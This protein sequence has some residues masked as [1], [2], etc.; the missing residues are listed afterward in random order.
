MTNMAT[1]RKD[2]SGKS[3]LITKANGK[4]FEINSFKL[5]KLIEAAANGKVETARLRQDGKISVTTKDNLQAERIKA[6]TKFDN[7]RIKVEMDD[8]KNKS[9]GVIFCRDLKFVTDDQIL[10]N[11]AEQKVE[12]IRR[13]KKMNEKGETIET[14][15]YFITFATKEL[16]MQLT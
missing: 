3:L 4:S 8:A 12:A 16:P 5:Q 10:E 7:E 14:G 9:I 1:N 15:L 11:L 13:M 2:N 6:I